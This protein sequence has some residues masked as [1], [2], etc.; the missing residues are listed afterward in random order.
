MHS[1]IWRHLAFFASWP[2][3]SLWPTLALLQSLIADEPDTL[4]NMRDISV[5][6]AVDQPP[7]G[8]SKADAL[9]NMASMLTTLLVF[10]PPI[11][12]L[13]ADA[14]ANIPSMVS[15]AAVAQPPIGW[16]KAGALWNMPRMLTT[17]LVFQAEMLAL[18]ADAPGSGATLPS[19]KRYS[20]TV[21]RETSQS[22]IGPYVAAADVASL[23]Y[24]WNADLKVASISTSAAVVPASAGWAGLPAAHDARARARKC[25]S[26]CARRIRRR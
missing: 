6:E 10:Q 14:P 8:W 23:R 22:S 18:K 17:P 16:S 12:W 13:K 26:T 9:A 24:P 3:P 25:Q 4:W 7:I 2:N 21:T 11:G 5:T 1:A 20:I 15:T 19:T